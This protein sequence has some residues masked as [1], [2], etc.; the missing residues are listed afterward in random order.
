MNRT[1]ACGVGIILV[2]AV[3]GGCGGKEPGAANVRA[4]ARGRAPAVPITVATVETR[5]IQRRIAVVGSLHGFELV[6][7]TPKVEGRVAA[8]HFDVGDRLPPNAALAEIDATDFALAV[9]EAQRSLEQEVSRLGTTKL[10]GD[11]Y[12]IEQLPA[13]ER[14]RLILENAQNRYQ[15]H[16]KLIA[17]NAV[18]Y[19]IFEQ[20]END[21]QVAAVALRQA[22][23]D[24]RTTLATVRQ[25]EAIL[26][27]A[28]QRLSDAR[29]GAPEF[30]KF[31]S[32]SDRSELPC[33]FVVTK[34]MVAVG[35]MI[36]AFPSTP[37]F[38]LVVDG[39]LKLRTLVPERYL[40]RVTVGQRAEVHV[41]AYPG[42]VFPARIGRVS[43]SID[44]QSRT[45]EAEAFVPNPDHLLRHGGFAKAEV[46]VG[47]EDRAV[48]VPPAA[49]T[50]FA[51]VSKVF[52]IREDA[53][54]EVP[55]EIRERGSGWVEISGE[56][57][58]GDLVATSGQSRLANGTQVV[59]REQR[60]E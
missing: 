30:P 23:L 60:K 17:Q 31:P 50:S 44:P 53:A 2:S 15:R 29:I 37:V 43:P 46:I 7:V 27:S 13:V 12:D 22:R 49:V 52:R 3:L 32:A 33:E 36:R 28:R 25:R 45:F 19:E 16:K 4:A 18:S 1:P 38:E 55:V 8:I 11:D 9:D 56:L 20:T 51:G 40:A 59:V 6:V 48:T 5:P 47:E 58:P 41:E 26:A 21:V 14:A 35:E 57:H 54:E 24:A 39:V 34:R 10:P 42:R